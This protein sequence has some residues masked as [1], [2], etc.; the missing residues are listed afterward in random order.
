MADQPEVAVASQT[1]PART[2]LTDTT[3]AISAHDPG[4]TSAAAFDHAVDQM[5]SSAGDIGAGVIGVG[6]VARTTTQSA[7]GFP[8]TFHTAGISFELPI[9]GQ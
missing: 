8:V 5:I 9:S 7:A 1:T 3:G 4:A 2:V 6:G